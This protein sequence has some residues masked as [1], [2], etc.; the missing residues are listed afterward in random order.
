MCPCAC[1]HF[2]KE[3][4]F[5]VSA[6][7]A[8]EMRM[9]MHDPQ[10]RVEICTSKGLQCN[11]AMLLYETPFCSVLACVWSIRSFGRACS[12]G[13]SLWCLCCLLA[14]GIELVLFLLRLF[15]VEQEMCSL[16]SFHASR[17]FAQPGRRTVVVNL[18]LWSCSIDH[19]HSVQCCFYALLRKWS[20][21]G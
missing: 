9:G 11:K 4:G 14:S 15:C 5:H 13:L 21:Q 1:S 19:M 18:T 3:P 7:K 6:G 2:T 12:V 8:S 20:D 10:W 16:R 17:S